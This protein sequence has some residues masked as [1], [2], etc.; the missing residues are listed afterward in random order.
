[1]KLFVGL[2]CLTLGA[3][4]RP[5]AD[6]RMY[7]FFIQKLSLSGTIKLASVANFSKCC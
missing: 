6:G 3:W 1:M 5:K 7:L 4:A 2:V